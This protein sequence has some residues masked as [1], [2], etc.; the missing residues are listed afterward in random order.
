MTDLLFYVTGPTVMAQVVVA[1]SGTIR[2]AAP[3]LHIWEG[4]HVKDLVAWARRSNG[5][6]HVVLVGPYPFDPDV[7]PVSAPVSRRGTPAGSPS[8]ATAPDAASATPPST[9]RAQSTAPSLSEAT[10][11]DTPSTPPR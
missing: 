11:S 3:I 2:S 10:A 5:R 8:R 4:R 6:Y 9:S 7:P 1:P